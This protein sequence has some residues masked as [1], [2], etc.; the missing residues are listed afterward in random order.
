[1]KKTYCKPQISFEDFELSA[2]IA[3]TCAKSIGPTDRAT[4]NTYYIPGVG[5]LFLC[6]SG[7]CIYKVRTDGQFGLCYH[8]PMERNS[9]FNS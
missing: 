5:R 1:M 3:E 4:C 2:N 9:L 8:I 6:D 7:N